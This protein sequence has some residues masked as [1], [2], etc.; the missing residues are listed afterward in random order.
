LKRRPAGIVMGASALGRYDPSVP[1]TAETPVAVAPGPAIREVVL[2]FDASARHVAAS[3]DEPGALDPPIR[4][5]DDLASRFVHTD[6]TPVS[7]AYRA[8][9]VALPRAGGPRVLLV[10]EPLVSV[11]D[12]ATDGIAVSVVPFRDENDPETMLRALGSVLAH[13]LRTPL[14]TVYAGSQLLATRDVAADVREEAASAV[15]G[16][17]DR[18][19]RVVEDLIVF[20]RWGVDP[21][22]EPEP[23]LVEPLLARVVEHA[24]RERQAVS[25]AGATAAIGLQVDRGL[26]AVVGSQGQLEHA[27]H[28]LVDHAAANSPAGA[29]IGVEAR[30]VQDAVEIRIRDQGPPL[31]EARAAAAFSLFSRIGRPGGDPSGANLALVVARRLIERM[32]GTIRADSSPDGGDVTVRLPVFA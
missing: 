23:V 5:L 3:A 16:E 21:P 18:L 28:N 17:A 25:G 6:G 4:D 26:P 9:Q 31:G 1:E 13:E 29:P 10:S 15:A 19:Y 22:P 12:G 2:L 7:L 20:V 14:T 27:L 11:P 32:G 30:L 24:T 8:G